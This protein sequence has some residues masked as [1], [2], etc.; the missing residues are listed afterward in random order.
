M[1]TLFFFQTLVSG[2]GFRDH[3]ICKL[4]GKN[5]PSL[6]TM[7]NGQRNA[8]RNRKETSLVLKNTVGKSTVD[9]LGS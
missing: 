2:F 5:I 8:T 3:K 6:V 7:L 9:W 4:S 1:T